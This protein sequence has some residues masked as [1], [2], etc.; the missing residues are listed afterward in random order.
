MDPSDE[1]SS[2]DFFRQSASTLIQVLFASGV[3]TALLYYFGYVRERSLFSY[4]GVPVG[5]LGFT[6]SDFV[7]RSAQAVFEP[8]LSVLLLGTLALAA[9]Q[10]V[11]SRSHNYSSGWWRTAWVASTGVAFALVGL[12]AIGAYFPNLITGPLASALALGLG[13]L[14]LN[15]STWMATVD[16]NLPNAPAEALRRTFVPRQILLLGLAVI[17]AFWWT[18]NAAN[19]NG[20]EAARAIESSLE[21]RSEAVVLSDNRLGIIGHGVSIE[22]L[23]PEV[24]GY[25]FRYTGLRVL[26]HTGEGWILIA[27]GWT[28][29]NGDSVVLLPEDAQGV[30]IE[31]RP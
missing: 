15:Y 27:R 5:S 26:L 18:L 24:S 13:A 3:V 19:T 8:L 11:I 12:G 4:F 17:A 14:L 30:R 2:G 1:Q 7:V 29:Y 22:S 23:S 10:A 21:R 31:V 6:T 16:P 25:A 9:H 20:V 28:C